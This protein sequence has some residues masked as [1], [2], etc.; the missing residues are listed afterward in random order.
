MPSHYCRQ[1]SKRLYLEGPFFS[2]QEMYECYTKKCNEDKL[3]PFSKCYFYNQMK[4]NKISIF[5]P[6]NDKCDFCSFYEMNQI[7]EDD[8]A[9]HMAYI[10]SAREEKQLDKSR[11]QKNEVYCFTMDMQAVKLCPSLKASSLYYSMKLKCHN[12]TIY[13]LAT[14]DC[15]NYWWHEGEGH[16]EASVFATILIKH[17]TVV[18]V[19]KI[20][21]IIYSDGCSY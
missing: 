19:E 21:I 14:N 7:S 18:C 11:A 3:R 13:N 12:Y 6:C 1:R 17:L 10:E 9:V 16:L 4:V 20:P 15:Y 5:S 2:F 8:Y